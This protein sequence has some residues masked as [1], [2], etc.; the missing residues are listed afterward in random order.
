MPGWTVT[1]FISKQICVAAF[2]CLDSA[3]A[4]D[5]RRGTSSRITGERR[6]DRLD[7]L[8]FYF[9]INSLPPFHPFPA[10][11]SHRRV[12]GTRTLGAGRFAS[13]EHCDV[14]PERN[15]GTVV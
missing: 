6:W 3:L 14:S 13:L 2:V 10:P 1:G 4:E 9:I 8:L 15:R 7:L 5:S 12:A 11:S